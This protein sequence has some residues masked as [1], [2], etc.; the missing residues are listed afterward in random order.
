M[1]NTMKLKTCF[2]C[3]AEKPSSAFYAHPQMAD[4]LLGKCKECT[5]SDSMSRYREKTAMIIAYE[6]RRTATLE[7]K[8]KRKA[9]YAKRDPVKTRANTALNRAVR[10]GRI[11]KKP[12]EVCGTTTGIEGHHEDYSKPL[13]VRWLCRKHH[14]E[15]HGKKSWVE[16]Y[17][18]SNC[19]D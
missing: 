4:G 11:T 16:N 14:K 15:A 17:S 18:P 12:C 19:K 6:K 3:G 9:Y 7:R 13:D 2:K 5:K 1:H 10:Q 8:T